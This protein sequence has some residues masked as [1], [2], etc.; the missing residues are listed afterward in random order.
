LDVASGRGRPERRRL[1]P[2]LGTAAKILDLLS[3]RERRR[4][5]LLL[6]MILIMALLETA[7]VASIVPF[8][9][10]LTDPRVSERQPQLAWLYERLGFSDIR[11]SAALVPIASP[12]ASTR[13]QPQCI[14]PRI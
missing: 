12:P 10:M 2:I 4:G 11:A 9:A 14:R 8:M 1:M 6:G 3:P 5:Y 7:G 13:C